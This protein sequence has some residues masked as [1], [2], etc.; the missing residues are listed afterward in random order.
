MVKLKT[1]GTRSPQRRPVS[2][3]RSR[4]QGPSTAGV[5]IGMM[6]WLAMV[7]AG[8][9]AVYLKKDGDRRIASLR[10][11]HKQAMV[12]M[13][14]KADSRL[15]AIQERSKQV[16]EAIN[17]HNKEQA[18]LETAI[19]ELEKEAAELA[20]VREERDSELRRLRPRLE[21]AQQDAGFSKEGVGDTADTLEDRSRLRDRLKQE[22]IERYN[23]MKKLYEERL[24]RHGY[25]DIQ[26]FYSSHKHTPFAPAAALHTA[27][28]LRLAG[29]PEQALRY[30]RETI[31]RYPDSP[32]A[33]AAEARLEGLQG[34]ADSDGSEA[35]PKTFIPYKALGIV[36]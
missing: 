28:K 23:T 29:E 33:R 5:L 2:Q 31:K 4:K 17:T 19:G 34:G 15:A 10:E 20:T 13:Q 11:G 27:E 12:E 36:Q 14:A 9:C 21:A 22:Y 26:R 8:V 30:Y 24:A 6:G 25:A 3:R 16:T 1:S 35:I 18:G 7:A 32:Y